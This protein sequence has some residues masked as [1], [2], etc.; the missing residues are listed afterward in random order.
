MAEG[1]RLAVEPAARRAATQ[2][3]SRKAEGKKARVAMVTPQPVRLDDVLRKLD[4]HFLKASEAAHEVSKMLEAARMHY[5]SNFAEKRGTFRACS[6]RI[7]S[8]LK[9]DRNP[10]RL[11]QR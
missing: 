3:A 8:E 11:Y 10:C 6:V 7:L 4:E 9:F 5:H 1:K 2:K